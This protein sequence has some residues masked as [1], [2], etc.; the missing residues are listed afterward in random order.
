MQ[1]MK[2]TLNFTQLAFLD[3]SMRNRDNIFITSR[4]K[5]SK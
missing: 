5:L 2:K 3:T 1:K 4:V